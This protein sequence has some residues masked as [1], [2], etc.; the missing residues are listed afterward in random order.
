MKRFSNINSEVRGTVVLSQRYGLSSRGYFNK[1]GIRIWQAHPV[2]GVGLGNYGYYFVQPEFNPGVRGGRNLPPHNIYVQ[3]LAETGTV[4]F[5][6]LCW[7]ILQAAYNYWVAEKKTDDNTNHL[8]Y[9]RACES[10]TIVTLIVYFSAGTLIYT[11]LSMVLAFS[12]VCR[13]CAE[14][15]QAGA[16]TATA[17][18]GQ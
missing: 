11:H 17:W 6:I 1:A 8:M 2:L 7:W 16:V 18:V 4:G 5:L 3:A 15:V 14:N 9:L 10:L 13:R 12:S